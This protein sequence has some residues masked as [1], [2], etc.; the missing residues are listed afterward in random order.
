MDAPAPGTASIVCSFT[1]SDG[2]Q[3]ESN[4]T[5]DSAGDIFGTTYLGGASGNGTV[6]ELKAGSATPTTLCSFTGA[7][8][9]GHYPTAG[10]TP[11]SAG[12]I[13]G[14]TMEARATTARSLRPPPSATIRK[15]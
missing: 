6:W 10:V 1:G 8:G 11:E 9:D 14:T 7:G 3:P 2:S 5:L 13:F 12:N 15:P 4:V